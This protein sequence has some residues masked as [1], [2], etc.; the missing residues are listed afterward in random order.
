MTCTSAILVVWHK[1]I[2]YQF[3]CEPQPQWNGDSREIGCKTSQ[4]LSEIDLYVFPYILNTTLNA[5]KIESH[6]FNPKVR[7]VKLN[8]VTHFIQSSRHTAINKFTLQ[9]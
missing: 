5:S 7:T 3:Y 2:F 4:E 8:I 1:R 9:V 6:K